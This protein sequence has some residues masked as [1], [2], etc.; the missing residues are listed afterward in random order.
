MKKLVLCMLMSFLFIRPNI[1]H[2]EWANPVQNY[3]FYFS[4]SAPPTFN[5]QNDS[6]DYWILVNYPSGKVLSGNR[7]AY[8]SV[9]HNLIKCK[10]N[11]LYMHSVKL[12]S[13]RDGSGRIV[14]T[15]EALT[16]NY[17]NGYLPFPIMMMQ[18]S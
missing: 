1:A 17:L 9:S 6:V 13:D 14:A 4:T 7:T 16:G 18:Q 12:Y 15:S 2:A 11:Q 10:E 5:P 3:D 8:S